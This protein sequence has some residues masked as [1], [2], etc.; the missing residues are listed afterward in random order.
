MRRLALLLCILFPSCSDLPWSDEPTR[1]SLL[2]AERAGGVWIQDSIEW[3]VGT[4]TASALAWTSSL[5]SIV[6]HRDGALSM[7][8]RAIE[9]RGR[10]SIA[11]ATT[12]DRIGYSGRW[13]TID[14]A[15]AAIE[16]RLTYSDQRTPRDSATTP[17]LQDTLRLVGDNVAGDS[18]WHLLQTPTYTPTRIVR[19]QRPQRLARHSLQALTWRDSITHRRR[20]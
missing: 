11:F 17:T 14:S 1:D 20:H 16:Y 18:L 19:L 9:L 8:T 13:W 7:Q 6:L 10:D 5:F 4:D 12:P 2:L 3:E 15:T